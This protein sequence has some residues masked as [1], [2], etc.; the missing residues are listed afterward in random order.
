[1]QIDSVQ[2]DNYTYNN[3]ILNA[4]QDNS[5]SKIRIKSESEQLQM[6]LTADTKIEKKKINGRIYYVGL[7]L[8]DEKD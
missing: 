5:T 2:Y 1:M 6:E 4:Q 7:R 3:I 8:R